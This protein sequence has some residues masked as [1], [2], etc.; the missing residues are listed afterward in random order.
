MSMLGGIEMEYR[1]NTVM[2]WVTFA[3]SVLFTLSYVVMTVSLQNNLD[4]TF[5]IVSLLVT[6]VLSLAVIVLAL[7]TG[8]INKACDPLFERA[9]AVS[10]RY[11]FLAVVIAVLPL[12]LQVLFFAVIP[13]AEELAQDYPARVSLIITILTIYVTGA[14]LLLLALR[15]VP[16][17]KIEKRTPTFSFLFLCLMSMC[18]LCLIGVIIG[19][20][21]ELVLTVPFQGDE[22]SQSNI[23]EII[24]STTL[25]ERVLVIGI[26]GPIFEELIFRKLLV[27]RTIKYGET[28]SIIL[29]GFMFGLFHGNFQQFFFATLI[30][31]LFA[32]IFIRT[33]N[34][35][36]PILLHMTVNLTT[37]IVT[38]SMYIKLMPY[39]DELEH[40]EDLPADIQLTAVALVMWMLLL[41]AIAVTGIV[42]FCVFNN[43]F[44]PYKAPGEPRT[45]A[46]IGKCVHSPLFWS[47]VVIC[48]GDFGASYLPDIVK[49]ITG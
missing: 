30:G 29:S 41:F 28:F 7:I 40:L 8:K 3:A 13:D 1:R 43:R 10:A 2:P 39:M 48:L 32:F 31:M 4:R 5:S 34:V 12:L 22:P 16:K 26:L 38:A 18:G 37:S 14:P 49:T 27:E 20:P 42:L 9:E 47:F 19:L 15:R 33:G 36:Y 35:I 45:V 6:G 11:T 17:M 25:I 21:F 46:I 44:K 23:A 24:S